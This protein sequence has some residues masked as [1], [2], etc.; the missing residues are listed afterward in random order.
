MFLRRPPKPLEMIREFELLHTVVEVIHFL[1][2]KIVNLRGI[3]DIVH[4]YIL[5]T[6][7]DE[8][9]ATRLYDKRSSQ[10]L[11][12]RASWHVTWGEHAEIDTDFSMRQ[13]VLP[14]KLIVVLGGDEIV[15]TPTPHNFYFITLAG[16]NFFKDGIQPTYEF[17][18]EGDGGDRRKR[19][20]S[21]SADHEDGVDEG[22]VHVV[23]VRIP[24]SIKSLAV[25][26][27]RN[28]ID[29]PGYRVEGKLRVGE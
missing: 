2:E 13:T 5:K 20:G 15:I 8:L 10:V 3:L 17:F 9:P 21:C 28:P 25:N 27:A 19:S 4:Q 16:L 6:Y 11:T 22:L 18:T 23:M 14:Y 26:E 7:R 29:E 24:S 1:L 12:G